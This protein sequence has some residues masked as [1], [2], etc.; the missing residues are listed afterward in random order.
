MSKFVS[1]IVVT[2]GIENFLDSCLESV[3][4]QTYLEFETI[5]ID[6][7]KTNLF[8]CGTLNKGIRQSKGDFILCLNDDVILDK[9]FVE[10][11]LQGFYID[12]RIGMVSGKILR[13][14]G[15]TI[16]S[17]G[18]FLSP[19]RT[20][21]ER[22][23]GLK[24]IGKFEK[25]E[26]I[27][28]VNGAVA[29]YRKEM[30]EEIKENDDYFDEDFHIFYEDLDIAWR[31]QRMGW[32][33]YYIP[34]AIAYHIRGGTVRNARGIDKPYARKYLSEDLCFDLLKNRYLVLIKNESFL[35]FLL[36]L[37]FIFFYDFLIWS[38]IL[39]FRP[40]LIRKFFSNL[41]YF[42]SAFRKRSIH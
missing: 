16:D 41:Q 3:K 22:G 26:Y 29:F 17:T 31:A 5:V 39:L 13:P 38:Y 37:P 1:I 40:R 12:E 6:N 32:H 36:N 21:R 27:F 19:W 33:A 11:A 34:K 30:L 14:D 8:Y 28:G 42:H 23:Y 9:G 10:K 18:L 20:V 4:I 7:S 35:D 2:K 24:D 25:K 15:V